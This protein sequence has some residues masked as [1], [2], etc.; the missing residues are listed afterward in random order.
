MDLIQKCGFFPTPL[1]LGV[2]SFKFKQIWQEI[3]GRTGINMKRDLFGIKPPWEFSGPI[4]VLYEYV[5]N[6]PGNFTA[7]VEIVGWSP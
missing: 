5:R 2:F 4:S 1:L 6:L 7:D 3:G